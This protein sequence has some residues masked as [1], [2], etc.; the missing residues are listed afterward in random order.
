M[1]PSD[2]YQL[3]RHNKIIKSN[4]QELLDFAF[5]CF[6]QCLTRS[7][8]FFK[9]RKYNYRVAIPFETKRLKKT[10]IE[11]KIFLHVHTN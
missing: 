5:G 3:I 9:S 10:P 11:N 8:C 7:N 2:I 6:L 4:I 1:H